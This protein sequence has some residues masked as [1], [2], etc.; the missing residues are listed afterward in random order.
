MWS[1]LRSVAGIGPFGRPTSSSGL[2][3][4]CGQWAGLNQPFLSSPPLPASTLTRQ[5][6]KAE[7]ESTVRRWSSGVEVCEALKWT[8]AV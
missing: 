4:S 7:E 5:V 1:S 2:P 8:L 6:R 3:S